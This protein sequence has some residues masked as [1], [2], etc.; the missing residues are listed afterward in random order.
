MIATTVHIWVKEDKI[1]EFIKASLENHNNSVNEPGN[2]RFDILQ[3]QDDKTQFTFY[4]VYKTE[5]DILAHKE[6]PHY[7][8]WRKT[9]DSWMTQPRKGVKH[10]VHAP[11]EVE[12]W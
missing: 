3:H 12:K 2:I 5:E 7:A 10:H 4:E 9:V 8:I 11:K 6:T 1:N